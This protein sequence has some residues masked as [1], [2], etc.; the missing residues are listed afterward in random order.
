MKTKGLNNTIFKIW[1]NILYENFKDQLNLKQV[2]HIAQ[3]GSQKGKGATD[4][5]LA[6]NLIQENNTSVSLYTATIDL[7]R[8]I[9]QQ[10]RQ[11]KTVAQTH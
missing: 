1:G 3:F 8:P 11:N 5:F 10:S 4:A 9:T 7:L 2:M 6:I